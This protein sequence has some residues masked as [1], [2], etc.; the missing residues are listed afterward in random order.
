MWKYRAGQFVRVAFPF[1]TK[2]PPREICKNYRKEWKIIPPELLHVRVYPFRPSK[3]TL[4]ESES[5]RLFLKEFKKRLYSR[6][7]FLPNDSV[8]F[9]SDMILYYIS[10]VNKTRCQC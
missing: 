6:H 3:M 4:L 8:L 1:S 7:T 5:S 2:P 10:N 9:D